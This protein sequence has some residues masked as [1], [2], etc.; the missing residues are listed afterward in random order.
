MHWSNSHFAGRIR[1]LVYS[2]KA[3]FGTLLD[4]PSGEK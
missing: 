4:V 3:V 2:A 1:L